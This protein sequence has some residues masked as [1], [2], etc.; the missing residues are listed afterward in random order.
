MS[1]DPLAEKYYNL[2]PYA[3]C[4]NNPLRYVDPD[5]RK[6][7]VKREES[8]DDK[9][10]VTITVTGKL[11]N[12]S[13]KQYTQDQM[14]SYANTLASSVATAFSGSDGDVSW[15]GVADI[16]VA[17]DENPLTDTDHAIRIVDQSTMDGL[18][19]SKEVSGFAPYNENVVYMTADALDL[20]PA[21]TGQFANTGMTENRERT[22]ESLAAHELGHSAGLP[23]LPITSISDP[24]GYEKRYKN[25]L[26]HVGGHPLSGSKLLK[27]QVL[28]IESNYRNGQLNKG[29]QR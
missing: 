3:Y 9:I 13:G 11:V 12:D 17:S 8:L 18:T 5:G 25:N 16:S 20:P 7:V 2:S 21:T 1:I 22:L 27:Q 26:M 15:V 24:V 10:V 4:A 23:H 14:Q 6:I 28:T 29:R 19:E